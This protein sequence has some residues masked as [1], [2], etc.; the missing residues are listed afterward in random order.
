MVYGP[1]LE[2]LVTFN[3]DRLPKDAFLVSCDAMQLAQPG[4]G[5]TG[6]KAFELVAEGNAW[7]E[8]R[9]F[10]G[11]A[12]VIS[13]DSAKDLFMLRSLGDNDSEL[14]RESRPGGDRVPVIAKTIQFIRASNEIRLHD[15]RFGSGIQ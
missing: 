2:P 12:D 7:L 9:S 5:P 4:N 14:T 11:Q 6:K 3:I 13:Y 10:T 1:V 15:V 8:G